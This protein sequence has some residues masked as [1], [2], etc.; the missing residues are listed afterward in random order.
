MLSEEE[1]DRAVQVR[2]QRQASLFR[3]LPAAPGW[4]PCC[5]RR[6]PGRLRAPS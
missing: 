6:C 4:S 3:R 2:L 5:L 1:R